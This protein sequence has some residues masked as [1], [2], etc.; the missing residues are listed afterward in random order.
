VAPFDESFGEQLLVSH[1]NNG[2][3]NSELIS[4]LARRRQSFTR[5]KGAR[6]S[7]IAKPQ[8]DLPGER[9]TIM[10]KWYYELHG[11]W[12]LEIT[13]LSAMLLTS[14]GGWQC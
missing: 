7:S 2:A 14:Q 13:T 10:R 12:V 9:L 5:R 4:Q 6:Q 11:K 8:V 1:D 3:R